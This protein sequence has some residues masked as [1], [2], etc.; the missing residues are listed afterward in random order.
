MATAMVLPGLPSGLGT[1]IIQANALNIPAAEYTPLDWTSAQRRVNE[2]GRGL[3]IDFPGGKNPDTSW[4]FFTRTDMTGSNASQ[5]TLMGVR[6]RSVGGSRS[7]LNVADM[8]YKPFPTI[9]KT[10]QVYLWHHVE[11]TLTN[12]SKYGDVQLSIAGATVMVDPETGQLIVPTSGYEAIYEALGMLLKPV[13][14]GAPG[15]TP[16]YAGLAGLNPNV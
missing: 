3:F 5:K 12:G 9:R 10:I 13:A 4:L 6:L 14:A 7:A 8:D 16:A 15:W 11:V 1:T 2:L